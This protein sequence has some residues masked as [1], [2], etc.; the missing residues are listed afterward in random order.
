MKKFAFLVIALSFVLSACD[1]T[2]NPKPPVRTHPFPNAVQ[3]N[4]GNAKDATVTSSVTRNSPKI[5]KIDINNIPDDDDVIYFEANTSNV[6][7]ELFTVSNNVATK[8]RASISANLFGVP[9]AI[10][11]NTQALENQE[12]DS[13]T[14]DSQAIVPTPNNSCR[15]SCIIIKKGSGTGT[16]YLRV[17]TK[18]TAPVDYKLFLFS[19][20]YRD[21]S[22]PAN[23][24]N[25]Q[26]KCV[27]S[28]SALIHSASIVI[29]PKEPYAIETVTDVDCFSSNKSAKAIILR[30]GDKLT[31]NIKAQIFDHKG[32]P[33]KF[34]DAQG[35]ITGD[36]ILYVGPDHRGTA[37]ARADFPSEFILRVSS[38]DGRAAP[39]GHAE[40]TIDFT[41]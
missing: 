37:T 11:P 36:A 21:K 12:L 31:F 18:T 25:A 22:E 1:I 39:A 30:A 24:P 13:Q 7:L 15:G 5:Y 3:T 38:A 14:I 40:Y 2:I 35:N 8:K 4:L 23:E 34:K 6:V 19:D 41:Y 9:S 17:S 10:L 16:V 32:N 27:Y 29:T 20:T 28:T 26:G 33:L